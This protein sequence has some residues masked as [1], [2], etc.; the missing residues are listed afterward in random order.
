MADEKATP[1]EDVTDDG[2]LSE[3]E[4]EAVVGGLGEGGVGILGEAI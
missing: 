2:Q 3:D 1:D 4:I